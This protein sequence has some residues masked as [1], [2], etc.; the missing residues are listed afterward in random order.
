MVVPKG[1]F[2]FVLHSHLPYIIKH[3]TW[4]HGMSWL[5]EATAETYLP[6]LNILNDLVEEGR[7]PHLTLGITPVL[8]EMLG[9]ELFQKEFLNYLDIRID[10]AYNDIDDFSAKGLELR[11][12]LARFWVNYYESIKTDFVEKYNYNILNSF[13]KLQD[14]DIIEII[15]CGATHGYFPLLLNDESINAQIRVGKKVYKK[16]FGRDPK[17]IWLPECAYRPGYKWKPPLGNFKEKERK[18]V[19]HFLDANN[20]RYFFVDTHL[21]IGGETAGVYAARFKLLKQLYEQ[22]KDQYKPISIDIPKPPYQAY[23]CGSKSTKKPI[24]FYTR[25][26][27]TGIVVW[28]GEHGYPGDGNYLD[29]HK[30][31]FPGGHRYWKV[32]SNK[33]DLGD[34]M[35]YFPDAVESR[36]EEN[37]SH[38][39][40]L[41][42]KLLL[43][44][45]ARSNQQGI[46]VSMYDTELFGHWWFEGPR[47]MKKVLMKIEDD[48]EI[49]LIT[50]YSYL[51]KFPPEIVVNLHEGSWGQGGYHWVWF[52][53]WTT[54]T[55]EKIYECESKMQD[56]LK[57]IK[58]LENVT[59]IAKRVL[60]QL[61][62]ELLLLQSSDWQFLI[63]TWS[64]RDY[65]ESRVIEHYDKFVK[66]LEISKN[67]INDTEFTEKQLKYLEILENEDNVFENIEPEDFII[68]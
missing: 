67:I 50:A 62:R 29:F 46:V 34:K 65:A 36:L 4:P 3:G 28:S 8:C 60:K 43:D 22:F 13:K 20:I 25:D 54:W 31:H 57:N 61:G 42:K 6:L 33:V 17:G 18:G 40:D 56:L 19:E 5:N 11:T 23:I 35:E 37:S 55:W 14:D 12:K 39:K 45:H 27:K 21:L 49:E 41:V 58:N 1:F 48:P 26:E 15:T 63:T 44:E 24:F 7:K 51:K 53:D 64:A 30:K 16:Y 38:F 52:N 9:N 2:T 66:L 10:A 68:N 59:G 47:W 32:T